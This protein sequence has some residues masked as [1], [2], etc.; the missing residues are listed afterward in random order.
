MRLFSYRNRTRLYKIATTIL[1]VLAVLFAL[2]MVVLTYC[3][4]YI[5]YDHSGAHLDVNWR[6]HSVSHTVLTP[7]V[8]ANVDYVDEEESIGTTRQ[9]TGYYVTADM[10]NDVA[11]LKQA[12]AD[13]SIYA[14]LFDMKNDYGTCYYPTDRSNASDSSAVD[15]EA[16]AELLK[17]LSDRGVYLI[18]RIPAFVD[19]TY[20]LEHV[21]LGLPLANGALWYDENGNYWMDPAKSGTITHLEQTCSELQALGFDEIVLDRF[22]FPNTT[23]FVYDESERTKDEVIAN[24]ARTLESSLSAMDLKVSFGISPDTAFPYLLTN[25]RLYFSVNL[26]TDL[27]GIAAVQAESLANPA[28]QIVFL[29]SSYNALAEKYGYLYPAPI[30]SPNPA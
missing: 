19:C 9:V 11:S 16:V 28:T 1:V 10:L 18:A 7:S 15:V 24:A 26:T 17:T 20:C 14:V 6:E 8:E 21:E 29:S 5:V 4:R 27:S 2:A 3:D 12:L 22:R 25:G 13:E 30:Q 23:E